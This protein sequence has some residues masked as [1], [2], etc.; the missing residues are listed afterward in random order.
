MTR[1]HL[2]LEVGGLGLEVEPGGSGL[3]II[4]NTIEISNAVSPH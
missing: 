1:P 3:L 4:T 2:E